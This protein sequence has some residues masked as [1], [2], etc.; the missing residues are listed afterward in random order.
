MNRVIVVGEGIVGASVAY[1]LTK[2]GISVTTVDAVRDGQAT[3]AG[4]GIVSPGGTV[5]R[6]PAFNALMAASFEHYER[7][8]PELAEFGEADTGFQVVGALVVALDDHEQDRLNE[9]RQFAESRRSEGVRG[10]GDVEFV[11]AKASREMFP[12][13]GEIRSALHIPGAARLDGR[14]LRNGLIRAAESRGLQRIRGEA[15]LSPDNDL[16]N[17]VVVD[18]ERIDADAVVLAGGAWSRELVRDLGL[19]LPIEPQR[20]QIA[21]LS[22]PGATTTEWP[23]LSTFRG[24]YLLTFPSNRVVVGATREDGSGFD[25]RLTAG[26]VSEVLESAFSV[27]SGLRAATLD[28]VRIGFRPK[29]PDDLPVLGR[30]PG[31]QHLFVATGHGPAGLSLGAHSGAVVADLVLGND[32]SIDLAPYSLARFGR[33]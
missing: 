15:R 21:H 30:V 24:H 25:Y 12:A 4:A 5:S 8:I 13:L 22:M 9:V 2:Q 28:E 32:A 16:V 20:G 19:N 31:Q 33:S 3:A 27:A 29:S 11:D 14:L 23:I 26:G 1:H 10:I 7:L 17:G 6:V 18:G